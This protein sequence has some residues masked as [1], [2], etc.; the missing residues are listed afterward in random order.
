MMVCQLYED[1]MDSKEY[2][3]DLRKEGKAVRKRMEP[4]ATDFSCSYRVRPLAEEDIPHIYR[5]CKSNPLYYQYCPPM[6]TQEGIRSDMT[7]LPPGKSLQDKHY[8]GY[9]DENGLVAVLDLIIDY[10]QAGTGWIGLF[11]TA[12]EVQNQGI[13]SRII[14]ELMAYLTGIGMKQ[15]RLAWVQDNP[16]AA[17]FWQK[18]GFAKTG[19]TVETERYTA[20]IA[21]KYLSI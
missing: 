2:K 17:R 10:P 4:S 3:T 18:N 19:E 5:L 16:Q 1:D 12:A 15:L 8:V 6:V 20:V 11:M 13:G 9:F 21:E 7:A 14:S